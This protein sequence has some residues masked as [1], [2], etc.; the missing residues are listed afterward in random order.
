MEGEG[1]ERRGEQRTEA[2]MSQ[3]STYQGSLLNL[4][5]ARPITPIVQ[6]RKPRLYCRN[7]VSSCLPY[8]RAVVLAG[9]ADSERAGATEDLGS[10]F[11]ETPAG[12]WAHPQ[13]FGSDGSS[14]GH[15][16]ASQEPLASLR[17]GWGQVPDF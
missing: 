9:Q 13:N 8:G 2:A 17:D 14:A 10:L 7:F 1:G 4:L 5:W 6:I 15:L 3:M 12:A 16:R 11:P